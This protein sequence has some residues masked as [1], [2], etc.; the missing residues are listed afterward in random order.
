MGKRTEKKSVTETA[1]SI[2]HIAE[3][4]IFAPMKNDL[5][6]NKKIR[7]GAAVVIG[8][9]GLLLIFRPKPRVNDSLDEVE[10]TDSVEVQEIV[11]K[12]GIPVDRYDI[13]YGIVKPGQNLSVILGDHGVSTETI[14]EL[15]QKSEGVF[16]V[17]KV[18]DGQSYAVFCRK[19][20]TR[21]VRFF[22]YEENPKSYI[23]FDLRDQRR[24]YRG[25]NPVEWQRKEIR[26]K[27]ESSLWVAMQKLDTSPLLAMELSNIYG[28]TIDFFSLQK[29]DEFRVIYEQECV[30]GKELDNFHILAA[31]FRYSDSVYY[32]IPFVQDGEELYYGATGNSLEGAFLKAPLDFYRITSRFSN[33]RFHPVLRRYRAHHG[34]DY[35]APTGTPVY[36]I[37]NG[38]VIAKGYQANGGGNFLKIR[39]NSVYVTTYMHLSR[40][41]KGI[42]VGSEVKQKEVIGY[43]GSTGLST[44]PHLDFRVFENGKPINPLLI[45]SQPKKPIS[46]ANMPAF[47][48]LRDSLVKRLSALDSLA[49]DS[50]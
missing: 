11:C 8:V 45:K 20:S 1:D 25:E 29:E 24:V 35:A 2:R 48:V 26:G 49:T 22:V 13:N 23:V 18:R 41:A 14:H 47:E 46:P 42:K 6:K 38:K 27:V 30:E 17:R 19:D 44:G 28:W 12:Y 43:V 40:F 21:Q 15:N 36:A 16:D 32:A 3:N 39:H 31:S 5:F 4:P 10:V 50:I 7:I 9:V 33:S 34:V 37:G